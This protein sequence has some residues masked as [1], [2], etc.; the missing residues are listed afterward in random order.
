MVY[1]HGEILGVAYFIDETFETRFLLQPFEPGAARLTI[2]GLSSVRPVKGLTATLMGE[3]HETLANVIVMGKN[4]F[5]ALAIPERGPQRERFLKARFPFQA[6]SIQQLAAFPG[7]LA[8]E[9]APGIPSADAIRDACAEI[10]APASDTRRLRDLLLPHEA[11][12]AGY[13]FIR[14]ILGRLRAAQVPVA[15]AIAPNPYLLARFGVPV[16]AI[17]AMPEA[18]T[19]A[20]DDPIRLVGVAAHVLY[21]AQANGS[22]AIP[23][24]RAEQEAARILSNDFGLA[25]EA[26]TLAASAKVATMYGGYVGLADNAARELEAA[27]NIKIAVSAPLPTVR[28]RPSTL[29]GLNAEQQQAVY[30]ALNSRVSIMTGGPGSGKTYTTK[31][32]AAE[33]AALGRAV[34]LAAPTAVAAGVLSRATGLPARTLDSLLG[35]VQFSDGC[36]DYRRRLSDAP[37]LLI[38]DEGSQISSVLGAA[39][40]QAV[41]RAGNCSLL[42]C[43]DPNQLPPVGTG[44]VLNPLLGSDV[45]VT[46][47]STVYRYG[48]EIAQFAQ[49]VLGGDASVLDRLDGTKV[50]HLD[51]PP[52]LGVPEYLRGYLEHGRNLADLLVLAPTYHGPTGIYALTEY[53]KWVANPSACEPIQRGRATVYPGVQLSSVVRALLLRQEQYQ[54]TRLPMTGAYLAE[55]DR[56]LIAKTSPQATNGQRGSV[57]GTDS[58]ATGLQQIEILLDEGGRCTFEGDDIDT[59]VIPGYVSTVHKAQGSQAQTVL[60]AISDPSPFVT[61]NLLFTGVTRAAGQFVLSGL[62]E[63]IERTLHESDQSERLTLL[64]TALALAPKEILKPRLTINY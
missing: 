64:P 46:R 18:S 56:V 35:Q 50:Q 20:A 32:I 11:R 31:R 45:P 30:S 42:L 17:S 10:A 38:V 2:Q 47:L 26:F 61:R 3:P 55:H 29:S 57:V 13:P 9:L 40:L 23:I 59:H 1:V 52:S 37:T 53:L 6:R 48:S 63:H 5:V 8:R 33:A 4:E 21:A 58:T 28:V 16:T 22:T 49:A 19:I 14:T 34:V 39:L 15:T 51:A 43:G 60:L 54:N 44:E 41:V 27:R 7:D 12:N 62:R 36:S 24:E 25:R